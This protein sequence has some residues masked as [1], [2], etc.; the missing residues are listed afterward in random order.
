MF[1]HKSKALLSERVPQNKKSPKNGSDPQLLSL[2]QLKVTSS[3]S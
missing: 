2:Q 1:N 3:G